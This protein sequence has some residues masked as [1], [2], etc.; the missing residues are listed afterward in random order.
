MGELDTE[1]LF[2]LRARGIDDVVAREML[3]T[4][5]AETMLERIHTPG[6]REHFAT[7]AKKALSALAEQ[8][9]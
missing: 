3:T 6:V 9:R 4:A 8:S 5:F 2:Y 7:E 1:Q